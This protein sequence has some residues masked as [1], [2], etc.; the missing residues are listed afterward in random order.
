MAIQITLDYSEKQ[1]KQ[2]ARILHCGIDVL[3]E[4]LEKYAEAAL[5]EYTRMFLGQKVFTRGADFKEYRLFLLIKY[6]FDNEIPN[7]QDVVDLFQITPSQ[8]RTLLRTVMSKYQYELMDAIETSLEK[9]FALA[10][11]VDDEKPDGRKKLTINKANIIEAFNNLLRSIDGSLPPIRKKPSTGS[12][13]IIPASSYNAL[14]K[15]FNA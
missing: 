14:K 10:K 7:E 6:A 13:Y 8:A 3:D 4:K 9:A 11:P 2:L 15:H 1:K 5:E 12:T